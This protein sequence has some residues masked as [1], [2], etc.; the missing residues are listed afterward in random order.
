M[1]HTGDPA[2]FALA[3]SDGTELFVVLHNLSDGKR[4]A[5]LE[6]P[7]AIDARLNDILGEGEVELSGQRLAIG[8]GPFG[9]V[10]LHSGKKD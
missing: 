4:R 7:G 6:L 1:L 10:W 5:E 8:L 9:Y 2:L 3:Y